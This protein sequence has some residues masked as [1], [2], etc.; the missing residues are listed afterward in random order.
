MI[1]N[2]SFK[3]VLRSLRAVKIL[4]IFAFSNLLF[5]NCVNPPD[6][7][8]GDLIPP[9]DVSRVKTD[10]S[11]IL[12]AFTIPYD[13]VIT[14]YFNE[15]IVGETFD[16]VFGRTRASFLSQI[17]IP[18]LNH[19]FGTNPTI[20]SAFIFFNYSNNLGEEPIDI[21]V[22]ELIDSLMVDSIYNALLP[23]DQWYN[24]T[25]IA[26]TTTP[27]NIDED[28]LKMPLDQSWVFDKL[29]APTQVDTTIML[30]QVNFLRHLFGIY[31]APTTTFDTY[32]KG[33]YSFDYLST[34][35]KMVVYYKNDDQ[36]VD[37]VSLSYTYVF[38]D[39]SLRFN[40]FEHDF[41]AAD[42]AIKMN[43]NPLSS[44]Q[45]SVFYLKGLGAAKS[46][47]VLDDITN[48]LDSMPVAINRAEL[49]IELEDHDDLPADSLLNE[50]FIYKMND[51]TQENILDFLV[52]SDTYGGKYSK[53]KKYYSFNI[54]YHLQSLLKD[55]SSDNKLYIEPRYATQRAGGAVLRSGNH[56]SRMKLII[57]YTKF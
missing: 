28:V 23:V 25:P 18:T 9:Q 49:R 43:F 13:T 4:S 56:S 31:V 34:L 52:D 6:F 15:A 29:I 57:T 10:T 53:S 38:A 22:Y 12:S 17:N 3:L 40:H 42:P 37:T 20:D 21:S 48:W 39:V 32:K 55:P 44:P 24:P 45:D 41:E 1:N 51:Y 47:I 35:S 7:I 33:M 27:Y 30:N 46:V 11:F 50:L 16:P 19:K 54:T 26:S 5:W 36:E 8:G 14:S 2:F